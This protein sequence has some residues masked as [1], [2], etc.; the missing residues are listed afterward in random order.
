MNQKTG[1][2]M[3]FLGF[4]LRLATFKK[5]VVGGGDPVRQFSGPGFF[6]EI[7]IRGTKRTGNVEGL[8]AGPLPW[9]Q[10]WRHDRENGRYDHENGHQNVPTCSFAGWVQQQ[11]LTFPS[12]TQAPCLTSGPHYI[13]SPYTQQLPDENGTGASFP[14]ISAS[15]KATHF[16]IWD[17][18]SP[19]SI[20]TF[21]S[22]NS[23]ES[24]SQMLENEALVALAKAEMLGNEALVPFWRPT[25]PCQWP[26]PWRLWASLDLGKTLL[27]PVFCEL[28]SKCLYGR[29]F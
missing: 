7:H 12:K 20:R 11:S 5:T 19:E 6:V 1:A 9:V 3:R 24:Y 17:K 18:D 4:L 25:R 21:T 13:F 28:R 8:P 15:A 22:V 16:M 10:G 2:V 29:A 23:D 26:C 14:S 27:G